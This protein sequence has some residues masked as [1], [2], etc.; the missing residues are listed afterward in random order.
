[1]DLTNGNAGAADAGA[2]GGAAGAASVADLLGGAAGAGAGAGAGDAGAGAG[3]AGA[4]DAG[5]GSGGDD[6][7]L[8]Q[9]PLE[10][11]DGESTGL[12]DWVKAA[13]IKDPA[14]MARMLRDNMTAV[15]NKLQPPG[16]NATDEQKAAWREA[17]G[18]PAKPEDYA[19]PEFKGADGQPVE[20]NTALIDSL[21]A[22]AHKAGV[23]AEG[24]NNLLNEAIAQQITEADGARMELDKRAKAFIDQNWKGDA[25]A[26]LEQVDAGLQWLGL[27]KNDALALRVAI[28]PEKALQ[29]AQK[30][31]ENLKEDTLVRG[32]VKHRFGMSGEAA[33]ARLDAI[34][35]DKDRA[36]RAMVPGSA[37]RQEY[38]RL[39]EII[40]A[41]QER[42]L[43]AMM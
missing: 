11:A 42:K 19:T 30:V 34:K 3:D 39:V 40:A 31:G 28:G 14:Q 16:E 12:R 23:P 24:F 33:Q 38:D 2:G 32:D 17:I 41:D 6:A 25:D 37:E 20:L 1:M 43:A 10:A 18:V 29:L 8:N 13:G 4:G 26:K 22:A 15:R 7:F 5:A 21:K 27:D 35:A 36:A 9:F